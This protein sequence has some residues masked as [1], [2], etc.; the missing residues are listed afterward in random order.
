MTGRSLLPRSDVS[1]SS[2]GR[3]RQPRRVGGFLGGLGGIPVGAQGLGDR[4]RCDDCAIRED[5]DDGPSPHPRDTRPERCQRAHDRRNDP[6]EMREPQPCPPS[7]RSRPRHHPSGPADALES[8]RPRNRQGSVAGVADGSTSANRTDDVL[9]AVSREPT[10]SAADIAKG[11]RLL[12]CVRFH[13]GLIQTIPLAVAAFPI[14]LGMPRYAISEHCAWS[15]VIQWRV[16]A[17][18]TDKE[19]GDFIEFSSR[20]LAREAAELLDRAAGG[21]KPSVPHDVTPFPAYDVSHGVDGWYAKTPTMTHRQTPGRLDHSVASATAS[22][23]TI[24]AR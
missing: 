13:V 17:R 16:R 8:L 1:L 5:A 12:G 15:R 9:T 24:H 10:Q 23:A 2:G 20:S 4:Q 14:F 18:V 22:A 6:S 21:Q 19:R 7:L 11:H 3:H